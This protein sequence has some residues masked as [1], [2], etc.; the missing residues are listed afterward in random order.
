MARLPR[1]KFW[2]VDLELLRLVAKQLDLHC[3]LADLRLQPQVVVVRRRRL[4]LFRFA[5]AP[6]RN[7]SCPAVS[8]RITA[9]AFFFAVY[10]PRSSF[11]RFALDQ[12]R[13]D[14]LFA[15]RGVSRNRHARDWLRGLGRAIALGLAR[16]G[17][18]FVVVTLQR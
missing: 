12:L 14:L 3:Q 17:A 9:S 4:A 8:N 10:R 11:A 1:R 18:D 6:A 15:Q 2:R 5:S 13:G 7:A 16:E